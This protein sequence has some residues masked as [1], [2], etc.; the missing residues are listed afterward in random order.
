MLKNSFP[1]FV[2]PV[3]LELCNTRLYKVSY[4][5]LKGQRYIMCGIAGIFSFQEPLSEDTGVSRI[6]M[7]LTYLRHR[8]P[9]DE[10]V[11]VDPQ[12]QYFLG[13]TRL[14]IQDPSASGHQP[15]ISGCGRYSIVYNGEIYNVHELRTYILKH[16]SINF[17]G[18]CDAEVLVELISLKGLGEA[19]K[20][21]HGMFA[22]AC[23]DQKSKK[24]SLVRDRAGMKP[25]YYTV[26]NQVLYFA[27]ELSPLRFL[28]ECPRD[29]NLWSIECF[30]SMGFVQQ[31]STM[32]EGV[33]QL[34]PG[35]I[36]TFSLKDGSPGSQ[37]NKVR[38]W[39]A[40]QPIKLQPPLVKMDV[41]TKVNELHALLRSTVRNHMIADR[42]LGAFLSGGIDSSLIVSL[43]Q[44]ESAVPI[45]TFSI[46]FE[47]QAYDESVYAKAVAQHLGT[48]H[49]SE[50]LSEDRIQKLLPEI[51]DNMD[52]PLADS[53][54][55]PSHLVAKLAAS[56]VT[57]AMTGDGGDELFCGYNR[58]LYLNRLAPLLNLPRPLGHSFSRLLEVVTRVDGTGQSRY[59]TRWSRM[60]EKLQKL[61]SIL[62][63]SDMESAFCELL[64]IS[65]YAP[66]LMA[67]STGFSAAKLLNQGQVQKE[68]QKEVQEQEPLRQ[69]MAH[70][71]KSFLLSDGLVKVDRSTMTYGLEARIPFLDHSVIEAAMG[72]DL[73]EL[74][75]GRKGKLPLRQILAQYVPNSL[76]ERPKMGFSIPLALWLRGP[77]KA[78]VRE[79]INPSTLKGMSFLNA[80][81]TIGHVD[82]FYK[83]AH[84]EAAVIYALAVLSSW[85]NRK[86]I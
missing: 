77:L 16:R 52:E 42:P 61:S 63:T 84:N 6:K 33:F 37:Q 9:D 5:K 45:N 36:E 19:V 14:S 29:V 17:K 58:Y 83:G 41:Q 15:I 25:L 82:R 11:Y 35:V 53:S 65:T 28:P 70:D 10:G 66:K 75:Q 30:L 62:K 81:H 22:F 76:F 18:H 44:A 48:N 55:I 7:M 34:E 26:I 86:P 4:Y 3:L 32:L 38:Y 21:I 60:R 23:V 59:L 13:H 47:H 31:P 20:M 40:P 80:H 64:K 85:Y 12:G 72:F 2:P 74:Y 1:S 24:L 78:W 51:S 8:G 79:R 54:L 71:F 46:G 57:V 43:M 56:K 50:I 49:Q 39:H 27:S 68:A 73:K 69:F 67:N